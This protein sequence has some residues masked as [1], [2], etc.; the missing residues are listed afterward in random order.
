MDL[1]IDG[2]DEVDED[3]H[4]IKGGGGALFREK[5]VASISHRLIIIVDESKCVPILGQFPLPVEIVPFGWNIT[6]RRVADLGCMPE[7]R[8]ASD[9]PYVT[10]NG[11]YILDCEFDTIRD[12]F[13]LDSRLRGITGTVE[14]GLFIGMADTVVMAGAEVIVKHREL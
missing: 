10:D 8:K 12:P 1:T 6:R 13:E 4:L 7:L 9:V 11:K 2:A 5:L 14:N 3:F